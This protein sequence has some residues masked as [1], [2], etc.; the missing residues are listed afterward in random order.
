MISQ[1]WKLRLAA[2]V[3]LACLA[4]FVAATPALA[5][6]PAKEVDRTTGQY[7]YTR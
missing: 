1:S 6:A 4:S 7:M 2:I 3:L 5:Q